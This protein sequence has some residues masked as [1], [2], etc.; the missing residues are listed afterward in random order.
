MEVRERQLVVTTSCKK[1]ARTLIDNANEVEWMNEYGVGEGAR[2]QATRAS[3]DRRTSTRDSRDHGKSRGRG[4]RG[5]STPEL[6][7][8]ELQ[9]HHQ[10]LQNAA[11]T[12]KNWRP[13]LL[14]E[15]CKS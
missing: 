12:Q 3:H 8:F 13:F 15:S 10:I 6:T 9:R 1:S 2:P 14:D 11:F 4:V 5:V 7:P